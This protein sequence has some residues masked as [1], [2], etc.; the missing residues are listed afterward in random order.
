MGRITLGVDVAHRDESFTNSPIDLRD[1]LSQVQVQKSHEIWNASAAWN[2]PSEK[3]RVALE[4][5]NL[6]DER[7]LTSTYKVGPFLTGAYN[8]PRTWALSVAYAH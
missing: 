4:G 8:M 3:W 7:V 5:R 6:D 2:S 1:P